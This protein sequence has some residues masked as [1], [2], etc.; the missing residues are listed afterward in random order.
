LDGSD[1]T[2]FGVNLNSVTKTI[3]NA[4]DA[5]ASLHKE[6]F[7][8]VNCAVPTT[9]DFYDDVHVLDH[10]Y[11][12]CAEVVKGL[13]GAQYVFPFDHNVRNAAAK[14]SGKSLQGGSAVQ[15]PIHF[16]HTDYTLTSAPERLRML[17]RPPKQNDTLRRVLGDT[18]LIPPEL[19]EEALSGSRR[20]MI[21][22]V[23][24]NVSKAPVQAVPLAVCSADSFKPEDLSVFEVHYADR[25]GE[26]YFVKDNPTHKWWYYPHMTDSEALIMMQWDT[27]GEFGSIGNPGHPGHPGQATFSFH[28]AFD[29]PTSPGNAPNRESIECRCLV[30][31]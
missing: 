8:L 24:R 4:R 31:F 16:V 23:W 9:L 11:P 26:N 30:I 28:S 7:T 20:F 17:A 15:E 13:T 12:I 18:S 5:K 27:Q 29:D 1:S 6:G 21:I 19:A 10:Y 25:V 14:A 22:N 3:H 2:M